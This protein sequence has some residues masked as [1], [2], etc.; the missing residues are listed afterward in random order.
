MKSWAVHDVGAPAAHCAL[1]LRGFMSTTD[2]FAR[3]HIAPVS[4]LDTFHLERSARSRIE[5]LAPSVG[6]PLP[7][8]WVRDGP[9]QTCPGMLHGQLGVRAACSS[10]HPHL[11]RSRRRSN[12]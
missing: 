4:T 5:A 12:T 1:H 3:R 6:W 7:S 10:P 9:A 2:A 11:V 8:A